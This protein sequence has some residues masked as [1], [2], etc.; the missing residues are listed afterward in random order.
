MPLL[1]A[2]SCPTH[3]VCAEESDEGAVEMVAE[4]AA[5]LVEPDVVL[6]EVEGEVVVVLVLG[7]VVVVGEEPKEVEG[8]A[9]VEPGCAD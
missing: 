1:S 6:P 3:D 9:A 5:G 2:H 8:S 7:E 4:E